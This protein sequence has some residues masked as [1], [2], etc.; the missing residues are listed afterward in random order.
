M[1]FDN[2]Y[3]VRRDIY[4]NF[5]SNRARRKKGNHRAY[6]PDAPTQHCA[7]HAALTRRER[8]AV[9]PIVNKMEGLRFKGN[10]LIADTAAGR[11]GFADTLTIMDHP[12]RSSI[13]AKFK[14]T[15]HR[16]RY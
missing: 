8:E 3:A 4:G 11:E 7:C 14:R 12:M 1:R 15:E 2:P 16:F 10:I 5:V 9:A 13:L 6:K